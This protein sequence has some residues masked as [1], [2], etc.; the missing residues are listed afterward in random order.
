MSAQ[1]Q[2]YFRL[3]DTLG[4]WPW[5]RRINPRS[6]TVSAASATW[7]ESFRVFSPRAQTAFNKCNFGLLASLAY[8]SATPEQLRA[9][10]DLMN[11]FFV[12]DELSDAGD[13]SQARA[14]ANTIMD[15]IRNPHKTRPTAEPIVGLIAK[16]F[17][18]RV[19]KWAGSEPQRRFVA[20]FDDYC[21]SVVTQAR[22]RSSSHVHTVDTYLAVRRENIGAKPSFALMEMDMNL[23]DES[24]GHPVVVDL[25]TWAIDMIIIGNDIVSYNVEQARGDDGYNLVAIVMAQHKLDLNGAMRWIGHYH[26]HLLDLFLAHCDPASELAGPLP[27]WGPR[28][29]EELKQY[30]DGL[31][32]WVRANDSWSFESERYFGRD[33]LEVMKTRWLALLP[34]KQQKAG[35]IGC[36]PDPADSAQPS[37]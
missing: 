10:C 1:S 24:L 33:G 13:E 34:K 6:A 17:W 27:S 18:A 11:L 8:P 9:G 2:I 15:G 21:E 22:D 3:P 4:A 19:I 5:Q 7:I 37:S 14:L 26:D 12:L 31:G 35:E 36:G 25:T 30:I 23:P 29:D 28:V 16:Q 32:N 20:T